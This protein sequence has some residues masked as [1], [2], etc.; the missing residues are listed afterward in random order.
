LPRIQIAAFGLSAFALFCADRI[1][2]SWIDQTLSDPVPVPIFLLGLV[3]KNR[4]QS[5]FLEEFV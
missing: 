4:N 1:R 3:A 5:L 2:S